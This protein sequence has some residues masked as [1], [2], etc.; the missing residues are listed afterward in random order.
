[1]GKK[2]PRIDAYIA[3][4]AD[5][6]KPILKH[7]R[8]VVRE[9]CPE[10]DE[11]IKWGMPAFTDNGIV[12]IIAAFKEHCAFVLW[13][14]GDVT[15]DVNRTAMGSLGRIKSVAD[16][17]A[18]KV[19]IGYVKKRAELNKSGVKKPKAT[20]SKAKKPLRV[21]T[22]L[23]AALAKNAMAR[24]KFDEFSPSHRR[25]YCE[26]I[27]SAKGDDTKARRVKS[28]VQTISEGK[29]QNWK[30]MKK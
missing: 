28:A 8:A 11:T 1:M 29:P 20:S 5:F 21:P 9:G 16:L 10:C 6:A 12:A 30:Y 19:L 26:W 13:K 27:S 25:E 2:D 23:T 15:T 4:S 24:K 17:P 22:E 7:L 14:A 18:K 3:K